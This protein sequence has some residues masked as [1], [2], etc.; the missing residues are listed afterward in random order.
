M[1]FFIFYMLGANCCFAV[2]SCLTLFSCFALCPSPLHTPE[3]YVSFAEERP[4]FDSACAIIDEK[5]GISQTGVLITP[6]IIATAAHGIVGMLGTVAV[7]TDETTIVPVH[8]VCVYFINKGVKYCAQVQAVMVDSRYLSNTWG[9]Q[10]KYDMAFLKLETPVNHI[11]PASLF[12][13]AQISG[14]LPLYVATFGNGDRPHKP[15]QKRAFSL[16]ELDAYYANALDGDALA[17]SRS[18]LLSSLFFSPT[19]S[20]KDP[21]PQGDELAQRT[22]D[23]NKNWIKNGKKPYALA[24]P[25]T[26]GAPVYVTLVKNGEPKDYLLG[27]ITS[28]SHLSGQLQAPYGQT[29]HA[30]ILNAPREKITGSYQTI[31]ALFYQENTQRIEKHG[32]TFFKTYQMDPFFFKMLVKLSQIKGVR[33]N[34]K[35]FL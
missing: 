22:Y 30:Y 6:S 31:L 25:G 11:Q 28:F 17:L 23:A 26:S 10:A 3:N 7:D 14:D 1:A 20:L 9:G 27:I 4:S 5:T 15:L 2:F 12:S 29:E 33:H 16:C 34:D 21:G 24:L 13:D 32:G 19:Q 18:I 8:S 35:N